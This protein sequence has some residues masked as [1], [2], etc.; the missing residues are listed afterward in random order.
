[1]SELV[2]EV[3]KNTPEWTWSDDIWL[4]SIFG[5]GGGFLEFLIDR[6]SPDSWEED[7]KR[8]V[9][10]KDQTGQLAYSLNHP[11]ISLTGRFESVA[12]MLFSEIFGD[13]DLTIDGIG[14]FTF[15]K[16]DDT[17]LI[18]EKLQAIARSYPRDGLQGKKVAF[19]VLSITPSK[20]TLESAEKL[21][22]DLEN[23]KV[24]EPGSPL[25]LI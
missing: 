5:P 8:F 9:D 16:E 15:R 7:W 23:R 2:V 12:H 19:S 18:R 21:K 6:E 10:R 24:A 17:Q 14:T 25:W 22:K 3:L 11:L 13:V 4:I 20:A 1:M